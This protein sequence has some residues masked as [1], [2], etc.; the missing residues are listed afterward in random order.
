MGESETG[1]SDEES[2]PLR[3]GVTLAIVGTF[4]FAL[5][6]IF[7]KLSF[8]AGADPTLLLTLRLVF[9]FPLYSVILLR[10]RRSAGCPGLTRNQL[11]STLAL[12]FLGYYLA[13]FLD[14]AGLQ[15]ITAQLERLTL[16]VHP[17]IVAVLAWVFLGEKLNRR[18][19][20]AI[21]LCYLGVAVMYFKE[22]AIASSQNVGLGVVLVALAAL[23]Y[24]VYVLLAKPMIK[25][26]GSR[27]FTSI[28][29]IGSTFFAAAHFGTTQKLHHLFEANSIVYL[30]A[31]VLAIIC[32]V[33]PSFMINEAIHRIGATRTAVIGSVGPIL[34][35]LLAIIFLSEPSS[36]QHFVGM[37]LAMGGVSLVSRK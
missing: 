31:S 24:S 4:L 13:S 3:L 26:I 32:T 8:A 18:I 17:A 37:A 29:M 36:I 10:T 11:W 22:N 23:S 12:G 2:S 25:T 1:C 20:G 27:Q 33:L 15:Y 6:S 7:I 21:A 9:A 30:Y 14:L 19:G 35:M 34:T 5:K 28:A 16:F